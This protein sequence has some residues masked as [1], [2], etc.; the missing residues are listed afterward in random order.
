MPPANESKRWRDRHGN[1]SQNVMVACSFDMC[2]TFMFTGFEGSAHD[3]RVLKGAISKGEF[4]LQP[5]S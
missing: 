4:M 2:F 1:L 3:A 5:P